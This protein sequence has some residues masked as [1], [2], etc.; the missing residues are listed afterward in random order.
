MEPFFDGGLFELLF[1][2]GFAI[3]VNFI[4]L[5]RYLL[6]LFSVMIIAAPLA[7]YFIYGNKLYN[8]VVTLCLFNAVLSVVLIWKQKKERP[9][10]P[11]FIVAIMKSKLS[12]LGNKL[13]NFVSN[14]F[15]SD[16]GKIKVHKKKNL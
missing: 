6:I 8:W 10:E 4:F 11:L 12:A 13:N 5:K 1:A 16:K 15:I 14:L 2:I 9:G 7:L 3:L